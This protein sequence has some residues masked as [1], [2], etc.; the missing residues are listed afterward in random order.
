MVVYFDYGSDASVSGLLFELEYAAVHG[1]LS[2]WICFRLYP[3]FRLWFWC[4]SS[5]TSILTWICCC[6]LFFN[7]NGFWI[8]LRS[9]SFRICPISFY[10]P[11][12]NSIA[13]LKSRMYCSLAHS[14]WYFQQCYD[15]PSFTKAT[16]NSSPPVMIFKSILYGSFIY[17]AEKHC[18][19]ELICCCCLKW[20]CLT[21]ICCF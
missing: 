4:C 1:P 14:S 5:Q 19:S 10:L 21:W 3:L 16:P 13:Q 17:L 7:Y 8:H 12:R 2:Y 9:S 15:I 6:L 20:R 18:L 11:F